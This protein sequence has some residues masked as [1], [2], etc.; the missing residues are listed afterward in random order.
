[1]L[2]QSV[3]YNNMI[4]TSSINIID[5]WNDWSHDMQPQHFGSI[6]FT[7][8]NEQ[9]YNHEVDL[10]NCE[11]HKPADNKCQPANPRFY[12][13]IWSCFSDH[14]CRCRQSYNYWTHAGRG[15]RCETGY[16][17]KRYFRRWV[18]YIIHLGNLIP[19]QVLFFIIH[20]THSYS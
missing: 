20:R 5:I 12:V 4:Q 2:A 17:R 19:H 8:F 11:K 13:T 6:M 10:D 18:S 3:I 14:R 1:M 9:S 15:R 7:I 16:K